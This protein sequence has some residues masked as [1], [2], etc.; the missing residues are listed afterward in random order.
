MEA[1]A[2]YVCGAHSWYKHLPLFPPGQP[3]HFFL[4]PAA[5]MDLRFHGDRV[6]A[7]PRTE[8]GFRRSSILT[9]NYRERFGHLAFSHGGG[10]TVYMVAD[11]GSVLAPSDDV[12]AVYDPQTRSLR[13]VPAEVLATGTAM[14]SGIVHPEGVHASL[15]LMFAHE[16]ATSAWPMESGGPPAMAELLAYCRAALEQ[17]RQGPREL[18]LSDDEGL[19]QRLEPERTRQRKGMVAAMRRVSSLT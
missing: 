13:R 5:G 6:D 8:P 18:L 10:T 11:D 14:V 19:R 15:V 12:P 2:A 3:F 4:D 16:Q 1:F 9:A 7:V 17:L